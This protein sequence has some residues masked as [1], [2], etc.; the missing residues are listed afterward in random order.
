MN[1]LSEI[2]KQ[3]FSSTG[4]ARREAVW[5]VLCKHFFQG[6]VPESATVLDMACGY[7][8]F[9]NNISA[10][11][12]YAIDLNPD[13][14]SHLNADVNFML[15][16]ANKMDGLESN[17]VDFVFTSNFLE[18]LPDKQ[19]CSEVFREVLRVLRPGGKFVVLG[20]NIR[21]AYKEYWDY[22]DHYLPLSHV[23]LEEGMRV[24]GFDVERNIDRFLP[25]TMNNKIPAHPLLVRMFLAF[26]P[27]WKI[28]GKQFLV[29]ARKPGS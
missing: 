13:A 1:E 6:I 8:E 21:Y 12:K 14:K 29:V 5:R 26:P 15:S 25:Y 9:I 2:Y 28:L 22:F 17:S 23:S 7:G 11:R 19:T 16:Y 27:A 18:H 24:N 10:G 4:L 20:P 3:R